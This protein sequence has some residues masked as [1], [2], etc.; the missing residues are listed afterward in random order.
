MQNNESKEVQYKHKGGYTLFSF[1]E[2][3]NLLYGQPDY[4]TYNTS[5]K[6]I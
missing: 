1:Y 2:R 5:I 3:K 4:V 6:V